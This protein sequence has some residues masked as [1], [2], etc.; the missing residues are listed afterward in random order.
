MLSPTP[1]P[2]TL[3]QVGKL[4][5][6]AHEPEE[7]WPCTLSTAAFRTVAPVPH[8]GKTVELVLRT[9]KQE[10]ALI[11]AACCSG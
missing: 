3:L 1:I 2:Y 9:W 7:I 4:P 6:G 10:T 5:S 8:L 11:L